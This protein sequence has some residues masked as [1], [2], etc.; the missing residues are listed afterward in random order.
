M[1]KIINKIE[2][3]YDGFLTNGEVVYFKRKNYPGKKEFPAGI[4]QIHRDMSGEMFFKNMSSMTDDL[5]E[6]PSFVGSTIISE[7]EQFWSE[8]VK[9]RYAKYGMVYKRGILLW[10]LPG[11]GKT[12]IVSKVIEKEVNNGS[13]VFFCPSPS[14][15]TEA[16]DIIRSIEKQERRI[17]VIFEELDKLLERDEGSFL[18]LLDGEMQIQNVLYIAT[19]NYLDRIPPRIRNRP[20]RFALVIE[21]PTPDANARREFLKAKVKDEIDVEYWVRQTEGFTIDHIKDLIISVLCIGIKFEDAILKARQMMEAHLDAENDEYDP[22]EDSE[23]DEDPY[24]FQK[25]MLNKFRK[26]RK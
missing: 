15:L 7:I 3:E 16:V 18:S 20:S 17:L 14:L 12:S 8:D 1:P 21:V 11:T 19:T 6:L 22:Y 9:S 5:V 13:I 23:D 10:G 26:K 2:K 4:Y 24:G 25:S